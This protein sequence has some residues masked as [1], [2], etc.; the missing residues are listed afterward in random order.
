MT[1]HVRPGTRPERISWYGHAVRP[2]LIL[3]DI[4]NTLIDADGAGRRL[5]RL[6]LHEMYGLRLPSPPRSFAGRTDSAIA[7]EVLALAG[8]PDP[9]QQVGPFQAF[10]SARSGAMAD[11]LRKHGR[12]LPG[13]AAALAALAAARP[14]G[15]VIQSLLTGNIPE[16]ARVKLTT[17]ALTEHLD[18]TIG[19]YGDISAVRA[20]LVDVARRNAVARHGGDFGGRATVLV[21]DTPSDVTAARATGAS[22]VGVATGEFSTLELAEAGA[23]VVLPDLIDTSAV[24][25]AIIG[26]GRA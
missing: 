14:S 7:L 13:A 22:A 16:L 9:A 24:V 1:G 19:A 11:D 8:V 10:M 4:D 20:D 17:L 18:L 25:T 15:L 26:A 5:Y 3:W 12:A 23:H 21:G 2:L 6:V